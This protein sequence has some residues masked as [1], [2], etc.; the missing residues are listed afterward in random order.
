MNVTASST[1]D[2]N[3]TLAYDLRAT[4]AA[5][6]IA[7]AIAN[8]VDLNVTTDV[9]TGSPATLN[10]ALAENFRNTPVGVYVQGGANFLLTSD[11]NDP[12]CDG[13]LLCI[14]GAN[15]GDPCDQIGNNTTDCPGA[16]CRST[17]NCQ[18]ESS[19][20]AVIPTSAPNVAV[21]FSGDFLLE[22][23]LTTAMQ[24]LNVAGE[25]CFFDNPIGLCEGGP[26]PTDTC[27]PAASP[28]PCEVL[29]CVSGNI[30]VLCTTLGLNEAECG[31]GGVCAPS[32]A[33]VATGTDGADII[34]P[35]E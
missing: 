32:G 7:A 28:D 19:P 21:N 16:L 23:F 18:V 1:G 17:S 13:A 27:D 34:L 11:V 14:G 2:G 5:L 10:T 20:Q 8:L 35:V 26:N 22:L 12:L 25:N 33:C 15:D 30:G 3:L 6:G 9:T 31:A 4:N 24:P 29:A